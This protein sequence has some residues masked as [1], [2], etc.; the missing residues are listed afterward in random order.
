MK[1]GDLAMIGDNCFIIVASKWND[2]KNEWYWWIAP[3]DDPSDGVWLPEDVALH[4]WRDYKWW[5][6]NVLDNNIRNGYI[7][8]KKGG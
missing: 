4:T 5:T 3:I 8:D 6:K 2:T 1:I 7:I